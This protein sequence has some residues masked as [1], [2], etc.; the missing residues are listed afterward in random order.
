LSLSPLIFSLLSNIVAAVIFSFTYKHT[1]I[2]DLFGVYFYILLSISTLI[3]VALYFLKTTISKYVF[4]FL[5][6]LI[7][8]LI[9]YPLD[10]YLGINL[11]LMIVLFIEAAFYFQI[12]GSII[13]QS[14]FLVI[15]LLSRKQGTAWWLKVGPEPVSKILTSVFLFLVTGVLS[16]SVK[17]Q[18]KK[19]SYYLQKINHLDSAIS[20][21]S[22]A[23]IGFQSYVKTLEF[24]L[25]MNERK[26]VSREIHD[27]VGYSLTN[28]IM[29][30]EAAMRLP[31]T[32]AE[33]RRGLLVL[34]RS[35]AQ[36]ALKETRVALRHLRNEKIKQIEGTSMIEEMVSS[37]KKATG[38]NI[39]L[40]YGNFKGFTNER[41][42]AIIFRIIQEGLTNAFRHG[43]AT[44]IR[45]S[46]WDTD[47]LLKIVI[48]DNGMGA[49]KVVDGIG[50][51]GMKERL[52]E[53]NGE[54]VIQSVVDGFKLTAFIPHK[55]L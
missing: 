33:K 16:Q 21:L 55:E 11:I 26:R 31:D 8:F 3:S 10:S 38:T 46:F 27:T 25:L 4:V 44:H 48:H 30:M 35:Q 6:F 49:D 40:E 45:I 15:F 41:I 12:P 23:N 1:N 5:H 54:L 43:M 14:I 36:K 47:F 2:G 52:H 24:Q 17:F 7:I 51:A 34:T 18:I 42:Y 29:M 22:A 9:I 20:Q 50:I 19:A 39:R 53:I 37:F 13:I 32:E 28:I